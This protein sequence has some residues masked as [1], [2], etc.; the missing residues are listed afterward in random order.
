MLV[1]CRAAEPTFPYAGPP[2]VWPPPPDV[3]RIRYLG[4]ITGERSLGIRPRGLAALRQAITGETQEIRFSTPTAVAV[5]GSRALLVDREHR[6]VYAIDLADPSAPPASS[7]PAVRRLAAADQ[8]G[9]R[10]PIDVAAGPQ[11]FA[12]CDAENRRVTLLAPDGA[13]VGSFGPEFLQRPAA[14]AWNAATREW[15]ALDAAAHAI[16][17]CDPAGQPLR[18]IGRRGAGLG[19]FN[20]PAGL[21][22]RE[23]HGVAVADAMNFRVQ[24]FEPDGAPRLAFGEKGDAAGDFSLPRDVAFD[25]Q[26]NLY[27]LDSHFENV[28]IFDPRGRLLMAFGQ[29]GGGPGEFSLPSGIT[30]DEHDRIWIA[31]TYNRRIQVFQ[32]LSEAQP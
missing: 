24:L 27:V 2:I 4:A 1:G 9:L 20:F 31:D 3:P 16:V 28:Q 17:V 10:W 15:W 19:E 6:A 21:A 11:R 8:V 13:R 23:P 7:R 12:V 32:F 18:R 5:I 14:I 25:S 22:A 29:E 30:I 26:G